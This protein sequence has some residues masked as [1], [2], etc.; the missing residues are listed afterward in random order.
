VYDQFRIGRARTLDE[1]SAQV[2]AVSIET[3]NHYLSRREPGRLTIASIGPAPL[4]TPGET[5][6]HR[7]VEMAK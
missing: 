3:L 1:I 6:T 2:D 4:E 7:A 5:F